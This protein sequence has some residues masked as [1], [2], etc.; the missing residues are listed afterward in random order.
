MKLAIIFLPNEFGFPNDIKST[1][2]RIYYTKHLK[3]VIDEQRQIYGA[4]GDSVSR[5]GRKGILSDPHGRGAQEAHG[6][7][8]RGGKEA[9]NFK[10]NEQITEAIMKNTFK[11]MMNKL[12]FPFVAMAILI[13]ESKNN[14]DWKK[15]GK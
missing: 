15:G 11:K 4:E 7:Y 2:S 14:G 3:G 6:E 9:F 12:A 13:E 10:R 5:R 1:W 8:H